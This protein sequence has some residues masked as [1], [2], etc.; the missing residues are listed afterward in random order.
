MS[1]VI[2]KDNSEEVLNAF[3]EQLRI[4]LE[5]VGMKAEGYAKDNTPV[6]TGRLRNSMSHKVYMS[7]SSVYIGTNVEYAPYVEFGTGIHASNGI[8]RQE[9]WSYDD[10]K[11]VEHVTRG[12]KAHHM[13]KKA[14]TEHNSEYKRIIEAALKD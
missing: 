11:G 7:D 1:E 2:I 13:I 12:I 9:P 3:K 10:E 4:G 5:A 14:A 6:D 8:G